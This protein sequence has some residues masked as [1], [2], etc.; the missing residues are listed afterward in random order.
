MKKIFAPAFIV[1]TLSSCSQP[2]NCNT[3]EVQKT[4]MEL[5][6]ALDPR[7]VTTPPSSASADLRIDGATQ[8]TNKQTGVLSCTVRFSYVNSISGA[9]EVFPRSIV[10]ALEVADD[11]EHFNVTLLQ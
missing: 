11:N 1:F 2:I 3:P 4:E 10:Y 6:G 9:R 8:F 5:I 7:D